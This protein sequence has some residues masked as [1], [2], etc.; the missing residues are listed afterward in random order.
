MAMHFAKLKTSP[1]WLSTMHKAGHSLLRKSF[2]I[3][4]PV[5]TACGARKIMETTTH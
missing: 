3:L 4:L 1:F 5:Y 2:F